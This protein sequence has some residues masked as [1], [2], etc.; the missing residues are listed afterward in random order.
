MAKPTIYDLASAAGVSI[1]SV[2]RVINCEPH[3][4]EKLRL[5]V[6]QAMQQLGWIPN[7]AARS[8]GGS[9][10]FTIAVL[11]DNPSPSYV[12]EVQKGA[13]AACHSAGYNLVIE[14]IGVDED[15]IASIDLVLRRRFDG[16]II[17]Q[18]I[19]DNLE[20][21]DRIEHHG[22]RYARIAPIIQPDR[23]AGV[24]IDDAEAMAE[25][26]RHLHVCGH[27]RVGLVN[28]PKDYG[29]SRLRRQGFLD[30]F[31]ALDDVEVLEADGAFTFMSG[32]EAGMRL[33]ETGSRPT[34]IVAL[35]DDMAAGVYAAATQ[36][37]LAVPNDLSVVGFDD[38]WISRNVWPPL[39]T[40]NQPISEMARIAADALIA[41]D[42]ETCVWPIELE[43]RLVLR[44]S[45]A[46]P[47]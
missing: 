36:H 23:S 10:A 7:P 38:S 43:H 42:R 31:G 46:S 27:R 1:K 37:R 30:A 15:I 14:D 3:V 41:P 26:A 6:Q 45:T 2:S 29:V 19:A 18:P 44:G 8:M 25:I 28:G 5:K 22:V 17:T 16:I 24:I 32:M 33:L 20:V 9:K 39:T 47:E 40:I 21:L 34:A 13:Y 12:N 11:F 35:N 4:S